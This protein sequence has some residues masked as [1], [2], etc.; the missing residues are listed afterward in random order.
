[1]RAAPTKNLLTYQRITK[2]KNTTKFLDELLQIDAIKKCDAFEIKKLATCENLG[3][4]F[5]DSDYNETGIMLFSEFKVV[6]NGVNYKFNYNQQSDTGSY[7]DEDGYYSPV[8]VF[9]G[10]DTFG[11]WREDKK[12]LK[13]YASCLHDEPQ[14]DEEELANEVYIEL[15]KYT[16][17]LALFVRENYTERSYKMADLE[18]KEYNLEKIE[19]EIE[20]LENA[21]ETL[22]KEYN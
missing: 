8:G 5:I 20:E 17:N 18:E 14:T 1:M 13:Y 15:Y 4:T 19:E 16:H 10:D 7:P 21:I 9:S 11:V 3:I 6:I 22:R 2:M 12:I